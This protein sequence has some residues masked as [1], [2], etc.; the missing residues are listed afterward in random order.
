MPPRGAA[1]SHARGQE[2]STLS[3]LCLR[4]ADH[5]DDLVP[6]RWHPRP[7]NSS[8]PAYAQT[9]VDVR[10]TLRWRK[11]DSNL[12]SPLH[13]RRLRDRPWRLVRMR[14]PAGET[15]SFTGETDG[16]NPL[17]SSV[18]HQRTELGEF[19]PREGGFPMVSSRSFGN[20]HLIDRLAAGIA[21]AAG[22]ISTDSL[23]SRP[24]LFYPSIRAQPVAPC[25]LT[26]W[27]RVSHRALRCGPPACG[28]K[29]RRRPWLARA[30]VRPSALAVL[31]LVTSLNTVGCWTGRSAG[32]APFRSL[33]A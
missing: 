32:F 4:C 20:D 22:W 28:G 25:S 26:V 15:N 8:I 16:S 9:P 11:A 31:R 1:H 13:R 19:R 14:V 3:V 18:S 5:R 27:R 12:W 24:A 30:P 10:P 33:A 6:G 29:G 23:R 17:S 7:A 21:G 2:R